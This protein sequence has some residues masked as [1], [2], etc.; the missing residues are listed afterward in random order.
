MMVAAPPGGALGEVASGS[1]VV[2]PPVGVPSG[3][4]PVTDGGA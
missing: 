2:D 1:S 4:A 3:I